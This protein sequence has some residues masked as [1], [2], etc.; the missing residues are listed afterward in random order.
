MNKLGRS[1]DEQIRRAM[2]DGT[3]DDLP[4]KGKPLS[5]EGNPHEDPAWRLAYRMLR[6]G[7]H[8]LP[9]IEKRQEIEA[10]FEDAKKKLRRSWAWRGSE[11]AKKLPKQ[12]VEAEWERA[13]K[14]FQGKIED[15]NQRI[16]DYNLEVP[17]DQ[18]KRRNIHLD[19]EIERITSKAD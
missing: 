15:V 1:L 13:L 17:A 18:F 8:T 11:G 10:D 5:L 16:S 19:R 4:G 9:W 12:V 14:I 7:G 2:K 6:S 3:F